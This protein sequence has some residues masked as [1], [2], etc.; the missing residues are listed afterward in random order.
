MY[1][2]LEY[3]KRGDL[4]NVLKKRTE[5]EKAAA[6]AAAGTTPAATTTATAADELQFS[7]L[8][9]FDLWHIFRQIVSGVRYLHFQ[10]IVHGDIKPQVSQQRDCHCRCRRSGLCCPILF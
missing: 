7:P 4:I 5:E 8:S 10:N 2:V 1:L 3:M 9:D 6:A